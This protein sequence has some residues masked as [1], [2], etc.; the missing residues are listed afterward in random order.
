MTSI[1]L[2]AIG[3]IVLGAGAV[4]LTTWILSAAPGAYTSIG[5]GAML[6]LLDMAWRARH[7]TVAGKQRWLSGRYGGAIS[8]FPVWG[9]GLFGILYGVLNYSG[10]QL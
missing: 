10:Y 6:V 9:I 1:N 7:A 5:S 3:M 2:L 4:H 8:V